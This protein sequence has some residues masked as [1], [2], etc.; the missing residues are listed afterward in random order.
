MSEMRAFVGETVERILRDAVDERL[1]A[2]A[3]RGEWPEALWRTVVA[4]GLAG[5]LSAESASLGAGWPEAFD[6]VA[7]AGRHC[8]P[9]PLPEAIGAVWLL[10]LAGIESPVGPITLAA[11]GGDEDLRLARQG[12]GWRLAGTAARVPWGGRAT[13]VV[14]T[15][16]V[17]AEPHVACAPTSGCRITPG[18]NLAG[19]PR[20]TLEFSGEGVIAAPVP[21]PHGRVDA[22][23]LGAL[24]RSAQIA[25]AAQAVL[26]LSLSYANTRRQFDRPIGRFQAVQ[27]S[28]AVLAAEAVAA[29]MAAEHAFFLAGSGGRMEDAAAIAKIR[30]GEAAGRA[31]AIGH[32]VHGAIG[33]AREHRLNL[34]TRRLWSWR[35]EFGAETVWA[36]RLGRDAVARGA[37]GL[38]PWITGELSGARGEEVKT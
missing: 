8:A 10:S 4:S 9:L 33:F 16:D 31:A 17:G 28:L 25:G 22:G 27:Q 3:E 24:L 29:R 18:E 2:D 34:L 21:A 5:V 15:A 11:A 30:A 26:D 19:E 12:H 23:A 20:D 38:W 13:H 36:D 37:D 35:A 32:Q 7:A 6:I 14:L 1:L